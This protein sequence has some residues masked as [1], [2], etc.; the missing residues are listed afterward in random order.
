MRHRL[1][2]LALADVDPREKIVLDAGSGFGLTLVFL[3]LL[4]A[5]SLFGLEIREKMVRTCEA[6]L[7]LCPSECAI[8]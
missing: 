6:Y 1:D 5:S 7:P 2:Q 3:G 8:D 4:G